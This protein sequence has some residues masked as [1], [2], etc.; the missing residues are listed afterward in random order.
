MWARHTKKTNGREWA[1]AKQ[2]RKK[3][4][5]KKKKKKKQAKVGEEDARVN[6]YSGRGWLEG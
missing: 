5:R 4:K 3:E 2:R 1:L 6:A